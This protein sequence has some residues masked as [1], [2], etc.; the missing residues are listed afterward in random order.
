MLQPHCAI[1]YT[2]S[3]VCWHLAK[4]KLKICYVNQNTWW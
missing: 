2:V 1:V 4:S 3:R